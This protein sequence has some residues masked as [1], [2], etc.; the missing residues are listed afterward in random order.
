MSPWVL[1]AAPWGA[2]HLQGAWA[3]RW[4]L[5]CGAGPRAASPL[6]AP[7]P[8]QAL[9]LCA[10]GGGSRM[11]HRWGRRGRV[12]NAKRGW[13]GPARCLSS[14]W[15]WFSA[16][17]CRLIQHLPALCMPVLPPHASLCRLQPGVLKCKHPP[18]LCR[19]TE[20]QRAMSRR[21]AE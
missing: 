1:A 4:V 21:K 15:C 7:Q 13:A 5:G 11:K 9:Y 20:T 10:A 8:A 19:L 2:A 3:G 16:S 6:L 14:Q 12:Q 18:V 17:G